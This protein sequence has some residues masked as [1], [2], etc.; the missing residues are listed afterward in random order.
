[1]GHTKEVLGLTFRPVPKHKRRYSRL[2]EWRTGWERFE[3][4]HR[5]D[6]LVVA[7]KKAVAAF[8]RLADAFGAPAYHPKET[9]AQKRLHNDLD[10]DC[11][12]WWG[13]RQGSLQARCPVC[14]P[15]VRGYQS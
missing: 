3:P 5:N 10:F 2:R 8:K 4:A 15:T 7:T 13:D 9:R 14:N 6:S 1:M 11:R 12:Y